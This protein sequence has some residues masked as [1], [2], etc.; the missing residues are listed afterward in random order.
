MQI[1]ISEAMG[2]KAT[3][4]ERHNELV[5]LRDQNSIR[6]TRMYGAN[7][8]KERIIEP[9]YEAVALDSLI[10]KVAREVRKL[11]EAIKRTN[12]LTK[13]DGYDRDENVLGELTPVKK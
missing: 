5:S 7:A 4:Q 2:W 6:E 3:L 9:V 1:T 12:G 11:D 13:V 8:D 10:S